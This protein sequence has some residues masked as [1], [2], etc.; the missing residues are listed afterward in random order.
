MFHNF[1]WNILGLYLNGEKD[2]VGQNIADGPM[3]GL[4]SAAWNMEQMH[5]MVLK[6]SR[7]FKISVKCGFLAH[8]EISAP[9]RRSVWA[10]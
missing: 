4:D 8:E 6:D 3:I 5:I 10:Y 9:Q 7:G 1:L 2:V